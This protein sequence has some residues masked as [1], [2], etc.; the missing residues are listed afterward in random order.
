ME[1]EA[2]VWLE[3]AIRTAAVDQRSRAESG[4][5]CIHSWRLIA[6]SVEKRDVC[7]RSGPV[8]LPS[9]A[10]G[11]QTVV[12]AVRWWCILP[13]L[14]ASPIPAPPSY[15]SHG[16]TATRGS[17]NKPP[18]VPACLRV[19]SVND[20]AAARTQPQ[21]RPIPPVPGTPCDHPDTWKLARCETGPSFGVAICRFSRL[22]IA[23]T[24]LSAS[25]D[26]WQKLPVGKGNAVSCAVTLR[27]SAPLR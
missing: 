1:K 2:L 26:G 9:P 25:R 11:G 19:A 18:N 24:L 6:Q 10:G 21:C 27:D 7:S 14:R 4:W 8:L 17:S 20:L 12:P 16:A 22:A 13:A 15:L 23:N 5:A 3:V